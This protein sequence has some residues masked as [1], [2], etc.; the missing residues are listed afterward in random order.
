MSGHTTALPRPW[1]SSR[2]YGWLINRMYA[3]GIISGA[4]H[5]YGPQGEEHVAY[6]RG[7]RCYF[8]GLQREWWSC[9]LGRG[10]L[11]RPH[12]PSEEERYGRWCGRCMP[13]PDCGETRWGHRCEAIS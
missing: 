2:R 11:R 12:I 5:G 9:L 7:R 6:F 1:R 10:A 3:L 13:C 4:R 8:L